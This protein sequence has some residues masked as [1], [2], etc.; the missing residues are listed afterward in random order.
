[1][2]ADLDDSEESSSEVEPPNNESNNISEF[3]DQKSSQRRLNILEV[4]GS[5][6]RIESLKSIKLELS[7]K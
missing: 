5:F 3:Q 6:K 1:M 4:N 2:N 7:A